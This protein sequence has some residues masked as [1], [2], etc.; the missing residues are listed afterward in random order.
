MQPGW[1]PNGIDALCEMFR[2]SLHAD[3]SLI[4]LTDD[5]LHSAAALHLRMA[6]GSGAH[7][8]RVLSA[9]AMLRPSDGPAIYTSSDARRTNSLQMDIDV[10]S[11]E[12]RQRLA[13]L[14]GLLGVSSM[15]SVPLSEG[16]RCI[17]R[18]YVGSNKAPY[19][20]RDILPISRGARY[21]C[22]LIA[23]IRVA[24]S[25]AKEAAFQERRRISRDLHDSAMQPYIALK[26]GLE[27]THRR[28]RGTPLARDLDELI[29]IANDGIGELRQY[30]ANL[31]NAVARKELTSL[32]TAV[33][34]QAK[35]F[36]EFYNIDAQ[37]IA[38]TD[39]SVS[40]PLQNDVI[41]IVREGLA[42][43]RRHTA[44]E[45]ATINLR[46]QQ[47]RLCL[48]LINDKARQAVQQEFY[49]R[50]IGERAAE[51]GGWVRVRRGA[52]DRTVVAVELPLQEVGK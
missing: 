50:S 4:A 2:A 42:N 45:R 11:N 28:L 13:A 27:A 17:G 43:I 34:T 1:L 23:S 8:A 22:S 51:L 44:A 40:A 49:P 30:V 10:G 33:R 48:E 6:N 38:Q 32:L 15:I 7:S 46:E 35:K 9:R 36:A 31:K 21:A 5:E 39:I 24:E 41:Q 25:L 52:G 26:L 3:V 12:A 20:S 29:K 37:V 16:D 19:S 18:L 14:A 47:G